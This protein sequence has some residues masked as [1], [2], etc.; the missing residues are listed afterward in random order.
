[1]SY[2]TGWNVG[3]DGLTAFDADAGAFFVIPTSLAV[4]LLGLIGLFM[5]RD[6]LRSAGGG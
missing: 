6:V 3:V 4:D 5:S 2:R 1:M